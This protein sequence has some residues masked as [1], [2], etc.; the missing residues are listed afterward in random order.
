MLINWRRLA[1]LWTLFGL[2]IGVAGVIM[3]KDV[4]DVSTVYLLFGMEFAVVGGALCGGVLFLLKGRA[5]PA[6]VFGGLVGAASSQA[7]LGGFAL[8]MLRGSTPPERWFSVSCTLA[9]VLA[10]CLSVGPGS[11][12][13]RH[14]A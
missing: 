9:G 8:I 6:R 1:A 11:P 10:G 5:V 3:Y 12:G 14:A 7:F 2:A 13:V 4:T